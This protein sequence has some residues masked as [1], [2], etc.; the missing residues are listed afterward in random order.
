MDEDIREKKRAYHRAWSA[1]NK[2]R[3]RKYYEKQREENPEGL[4]RS[5]RKWQEKN[6]EKVKEASR[7]Y[8]ERNRQK[9]LEKTRQ[10]NASL[11]SYYSRTYQA[12]R[13]KASPRWL[14]KS[15]KEQMKQFYILARRFSEE[16]GIKH[17][18]DHIIPLRSSTVC[19]LHVPWNLQVITLVE[20]SKKHN[21]YD[22]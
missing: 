22:R 7:R 6:K 16:T 14:N 9:I 11:N 18:V 4:K 17:T 5:A 20:N 10:R 8:Y 12:R 13:L 21:S 19:G 1:K 3:L 15:Q 2:D